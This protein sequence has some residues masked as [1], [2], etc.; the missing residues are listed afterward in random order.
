M[1][2]PGQGS[3][4]DLVGRADEIGVIENAVS[5]TLDGHGAVLLLS[6]EPGIGKSTLARAAA[7]LSEAHG[8]SVYWGFSWEAG[9]APAY[10]P[11]TQLLRSL[12]AERGIVGGQANGLAQI[13]PEVAPGLADDSALQPEQARFRLLEAVRL[14]LAG[15]T[16]DSPVMLV[17]EDLHAADNDSLNLLHYIARHAASMPLLI[18][19]T[20]REFEA[21]ASKRTEALWQTAR[22]ATVLQLRRLDEPDIRRYLDRRGADVPDDDTVRR[23]LQTTTGNP[24]FLTELVGLLSRDGPDAIASSPLPDSVQQVIRQQVELLPAAT[25]DTLAAAS[26]FGRDFALARLSGI[27]GESQAA[28]LQC[29]QAAFDADFLSRLPDGRYR[30]GHVLCR[31]VLYQDLGA[32]RRARLHLKCAGQLR[33]LIDAGDPDGWSSLANHLLHAGPEHRLAA[34][35]ALRN[36]A[37]RARERL[38]F[39]EAAALLQRALTAFGEGPRYDPVERC[40]LLVDCA[41]ALLVTGEIQAGQAHCREAFAIA[42]AVDDPL[43]MSDVALAWGSAIV[44]ARV[45]QQLV[46]ALEEC[47]ARLS[48]EDAATRSRVQARLAGALQPA[49]D[50]SG[51]MA[52]AREAIALARTTG[53]DEVLYEVIRYAVAALMDF[54]PAE[55]RI[56][57]NREFGA[58]AAKF[59]DV[60]QQFRSRLLAAI[61]A[62]ES[63]DRDMMDHAIEACSKLAD[64]IGLPHYQWRAASVRAMQ[65]IID[66]NFER[67]S[68]LLDRAWK[69]AE[70]AEDLQARV[71]LS[72]QQFALLVEWDSPAAM[73]LDEIEAQL[74]TAYDGGIGD[75]EFF[76]APF[77]AVFKQA[78]DQQFAKQFVADE[79]LVQRTFAG[80]D[81]YSVTGLG[82]MALKAG[83]PALAERCYETLLKFQDGCATLGLMGSCWCGP[84]AYALGT[85]ALGLGRHDTAKE[86]FDRALAIATRM[87]SRPCIARIH[88]SAAEL[89]RATGDLDGAKEHAGIAASLISEL[90]LRPVRKV[91]GGE[92]PPQAAPGTAPF[93]MQPNGDVWT[94]AYGGQSA[95]VRDSKGLG[96]LAK[97]IEHPD[98]EIHVFDLAGLQ[99]PEGGDAGPLLDDRARDQYRRRV[100]ALREELQD[101]E[102]LNDAGRADALRSELDFVSREL[103]RA[104]GLGG[105]RRAAGDTAERARVNVRRRI[106]AAVERIA[107][108]C[109][110]AGRYLENTI[111]TGRYCKYTPM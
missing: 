63:G 104:Y 97:L 90:A 65:A 15:N 71:T 96:M 28:I 45:D 77:I 39:D 103:S 35:E 99:A 91:P 36:A 21:R 76:V 23:L 92:P 101:A 20:Y 26:V 16:A 66:G 32:T 4:D 70:R 61:D 94:I 56:A 52:M 46:S 24:L 82:Q 33:T 12:V 43:L 69:L 95:T 54:A 5:A 50:P 34:I 78:E 40:R 75:A 42:R 109:P 38:A 22:E 98:A 107:E 81:R 55:E 87:R 51:P 102:S 10:W 8:I 108:Q 14:L 37:S 3:I 29:L 89:A 67:A 11:W 27:T 19:G 111:K 86:H 83:N 64:N 93:S 105:R 31:D 57:L 62:S 49:M 41:R 60:P 6:G 84:V 88:A 44:V 25:V 79:P 30:F 1:V 58:L 17:L 18:V 110:D 48:V 9:G 59:R 80:G 13:L 106:K 68:R 53:D 72:I 2:E 74:K 100:E 73:P 47:L 7:Q 85:I